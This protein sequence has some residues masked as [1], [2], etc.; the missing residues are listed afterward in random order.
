MKKL[1]FLLLIFLSCYESE[2][3]IEAPV[4]TTITIFPFPENEVV[5]NTT[6]TTNTTKPFKNSAREAM[7]R[8]EKERENFDK[9]WQEYMKEDIVLSDYEKEVNKKFRELWSWKGSKWEAEK[10]NF[11]EIHINGVSCRRIWNAMGSALLDQ[12][13]PLNNIL[14]NENPF[15]RNYRSHHYRCFLTEEQLKQPELVKQTDYLFGTPF[16]YQ[17]TWWIFQSIS[18]EISVWDLIDCKG[19]CSYSYYTF[20]TRVAIDDNEELDL[21]MQEFFN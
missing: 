12:N 14:D 3:V 9:A 8:R 20:A 5:S 18:S 17:E 21:F 11:Y 6:T 15:Y 2:I 10:E 13:H 4:R 16:Y 1:L 7:E 19:P